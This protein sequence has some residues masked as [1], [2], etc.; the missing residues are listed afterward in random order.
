M[1]TN[2]PIFSDEVN[3]IFQELYYKLVFLLGYTE[4][5]EEKIYKGLYDEID[6]KIY[7]LTNSSILQEIDDKLVYNTPVPIP[8]YSTW[9]AYI[10]IN[11]LRS[12]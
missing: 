8:L 12:L 9:G 10:V 1:R 3:D 11:E 6:S 7:T 4:S 5:N 2:Y